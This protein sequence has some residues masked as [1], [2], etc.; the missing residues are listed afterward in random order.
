MRERVYRWYKEIRA[1][2][3]GVGNDSPPELIDEKISELDRIE[4]EVQ[5]VSVPPGYS[6]D[7]YHLRLHIGYVRDHLRRE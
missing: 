5:A 4:T 6:E 2:E 1:I 7:L 3:L